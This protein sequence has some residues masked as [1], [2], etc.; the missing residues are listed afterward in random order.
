MF[1]A[2]F[3]QVADKSVTG[4]R[5]I[6]HSSESREHGRRPALRQDRSNGIWV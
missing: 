3:R 1:K 4:L 2:G 6:I 5:Q